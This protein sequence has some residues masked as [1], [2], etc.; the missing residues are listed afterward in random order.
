VLGYQPVRS[1][2][3]SAF[4]KGSPLGFSK[5]PQERVKVVVLDSVALHSSRIGMVA[6]AVEP[7]AFCRRR[8]KHE[9]FGR[10]IG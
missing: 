10:N 8:L 1:V 9:H 3:D 4:G 5:S 2:F 7:G 6:S